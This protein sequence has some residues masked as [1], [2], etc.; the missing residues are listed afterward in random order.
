MSKITYLN[1]IYL[2]GIVWAFLFVG[3][4]E[5]K[6]TDSNNNQ[7]QYRGTSDHNGVYQEAAFQIYSLNWDFQSAGSIR[8]TATSSGDL[9][10]SGSAD[11]NVYALQSSNGAEVWRF[12]TGGAVHCKP[13]VFHNQVFFTSRDNC[14]YSIDAHTGKMKWK[15]QTGDLLPHDWGWEHYL[16]SPVV[17]GS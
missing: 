15:F 13:A 1:I 8:G 6:K 10:Y 9:L 5:I 14:I 17:S 7:S 3:C 11:G 4:N 2:A 12:K 16:S